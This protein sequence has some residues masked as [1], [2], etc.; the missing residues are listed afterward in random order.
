MTKPILSVD[1]D[2]VIHSY[3]SGWKGATIIPDAPVPGALKFLRAAV[4][5]FR[6]CVFSSRSHEPGGVQAMQLW[7]WNN[8]Q[9][10]E[11]IVEKEGVRWYTEIEWPKIKPPA[12]LTLDDRAI[13]FDGT[14]PSIESLKVFK[15]WNKR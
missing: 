14:W 10:C 13:T 1:F 5:H 15:P 9:M 6:V 8:I 11:N 4:E 12:F 3:T 7:L 2:G